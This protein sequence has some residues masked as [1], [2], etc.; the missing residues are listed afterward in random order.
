MHI[1][2]QLQIA[3][4]VHD[5]SERASAENMGVCLYGLY[6]CKVSRPRA[7]FDMLLLYSS[8]PDCLNIHISSQRAQLDH[9]CPQNVLEWNSS[10]KFHFCFKCINTPK[11]ELFSSKRWSKLALAQLSVMDGLMFKPF[12]TLATWNCKHNLKRVSSF[13]NYLPIIQG[14]SRYELLFHFLAPWTFSLETW[15]QLWCFCSKADLG[16]KHFRSSGLAFLLDLFIFPAHF[17][18][19]CFETSK[20]WSAPF[21]LFARLHHWSRCNEACFVAFTLN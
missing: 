7:H 1:F 18:R 14:R 15:P 9:C 4:C 20:L 6:V 12:C 2:L 10:F 8:V 19:G 11:I 17:A 16:L 3:I 5:H 13:I 21:S